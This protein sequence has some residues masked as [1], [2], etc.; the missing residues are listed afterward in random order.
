MSSGRRELPQRPSS[1]LVVV[2]AVSLA[3]FVQGFL[4]FTSALLTYNEAFNSSFSF[5]NE[6]VYDVF[7]LQLIA[8]LLFGEAVGAMV[9][10]PFGNILSRRWNMGIFCMVTVAMIIWSSFAGSV[11]S[12]LLSRFFMGVSM[13]PLLCTVPIYIAEIAHRSDRGS[14]FAIIQTANVMGCVVGAVLFS[15]VHDSTSTEFL[16]HTVKIQHQEP[17]SLSNGNVPGSMHMQWRRRL[18]L[19]SAPQG[20]WKY[21][22][23]TEMQKQILASNST[24]GSFHQSSEGILY[25]G[26]GG[27]FMTNIRQSCAESWRIITLFA[28]APLLVLTT[29]A[30]TIAPESP[31]WLLL[32]GMVDE[33]YAALEQARGMTQHVRQEFDEMQSGLTNKYG[34]VGFAD[35]LSDR[36][37]LYRCLT[38]VAL[39]A[40]QPLAGNLMLYLFADEMTDILGMHSSSLVIALGLTGGLVGALVGYYHLDYWGRRFVMLGGVGLMCCSWLFA[41]GCVLVGDLEHGSAEVFETSRILSFLFG[42]FFALFAF[43]YSLSLGPLAMSTPVET[44]PIES[45]PTAVSISYFS[46]FVS[47]GLFAIYLGL[48]MQKADHIASQ[49]D[50]RADTGEAETDRQVGLFY[51]LRS[52]LSITF[53]GRSNALGNDDDW[54]LFFV[55]H[56]FVGFI[57]LFAC[58]CAFLWTLAYFF[59]PEISS[60]HLEDVDMYICDKARLLAYKREVRRAMTAAKPLLGSDDVRDTYTTNIG[61]PG[62][63]KEGTGAVA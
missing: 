45:R 29:V 9:H 14:C 39:N 49:H 3:F 5:Q 59:L 30:S 51:V 61:G 8:A 57:W 60:L 43:A 35:I 46:H 42:D 40:C 1:P 24:H 20:L 28:I 19:H 48:Y 27:A 21:E 50:E 56:G 63:S 55:D 18:Q 26:D 47:S 10:I 62:C 41:A 36:A 17:P 16:P 13:A 11:H 38:C 25:D 37:L 4:L 33:G 53:D 23:T 31:R 2:V 58:V 7:S 15:R 52:M 44:F 12:L 54:E 22:D 6:Q 32:K 34:R